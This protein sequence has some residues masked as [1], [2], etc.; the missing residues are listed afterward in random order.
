MSADNVAKANMVTIPEVEFYVSVT[1]AYTV[2]R[3]SDDI[4]KSQ[5]SCYTNRPMTDFGI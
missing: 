4:V 5:H 2:K 3:P 1:W